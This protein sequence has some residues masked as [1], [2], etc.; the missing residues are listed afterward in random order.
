MY[1]MHT[2]QK[3]HRQQCQLAQQAQNLLYMKVANTYQTVSQH[4]LSAGSFQASLLLPLHLSAL[5]KDARL[6]MRSFIAPNT[7]PDSDA[8]AG[9]EEGLCLCSTARTWRLRSRKVNR[10]P[11][12]C[13]LAATASLLAALVFFSSKMY[14]WCLHRHACFLTPREHYP[15]TPD[16]G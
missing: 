13:S 9:Q 14:R 6:H 3:T 10:G 8:L 5:V 2:P 15:T 1:K 7:E 11:I 16:H 12:S 4:K